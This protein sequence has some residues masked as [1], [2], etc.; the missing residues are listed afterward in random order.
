[1]KFAPIAKV[2]E[3]ELSPVGVVATIEFRKLEPV[4][5]G[6]GGL[7]SSPNWD[8]HSHE[9]HPLLC[10]RF[11]YLIVKKPHSAKAVRLI[12]YITDD[13]VARHGRMSA[14]VKQKDRNRLGRVVCA[15]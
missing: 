1:L 2:G 6:Y 4:I 7:V 12:L 13:V 14:K 5:I 15:D 11:G 9:D 10:S 3:V 8:L